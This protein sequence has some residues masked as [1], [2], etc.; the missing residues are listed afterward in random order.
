MPPDPPS[1]FTITERTQWPYQSK[2]AGA[3]PAHTWKTSPK[4]NEILDTKSGVV[5][6]ITGSAQS[7]LTT[8]TKDGA[9]N[10]EAP[11][12]PEEI[13][14]LVRAVLYG[15]S[16]FEPKLTIQATESGERYSKNDPPRLAVRSRI[17]GPTGP[18]IAAMAGPPCRG[19]FHS[20]HCEFCGWEVGQEGWSWLCSQP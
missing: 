7:H 6:T 18:N 20:W 14:Y 8:T 11:T 16:N 1:L 17:N 4:Y 12:Q 19:W 9:Q 5:R 3:G 10:T 2:I 15:R 13:G